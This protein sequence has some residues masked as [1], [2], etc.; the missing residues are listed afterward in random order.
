MSVL[1]LVVSSVAAVGSVGAAVVALVIA[2]RASRRTDRERRDAAEAQA[3]LVQVEVVQLHG[4]V[5][6]YVRIHN[7]GDRAIIGAAVTAAWFFGHPEYTWRN[8]ATR[9]YPELSVRTAR[10]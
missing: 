7:Y 2:G 8:R 9:H 3:R 1:E 4:V 5:D 6:F 10:D